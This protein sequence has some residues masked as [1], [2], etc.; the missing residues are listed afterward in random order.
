METL[1]LQLDHGLRS[2]RLSLELELGAETV[3][4]VGPSGAGKSSVLRAIAGL[5]RPEHGVVRLGDERWLDT[6]NGIDV[7]PERRRVGLVFQEYALFPHLSVRANVEFGGRARA[8]ELLERFRIGHLADARPTAISGGE[9]QRVAVARALARDPGVLLLDEPL[10]ALDAYTRAHVRTE[11]R[12]LLQE[13][14]LPTV[15]VTH[16]FDDAAALADR[17]GVLVDG[18]LLQVAGPSELVASPADS[19]VAGFTGANVLRGIASEGPDG[20]TAV[21]LDAGFTAYT[22]DPGRGGVTLA[23]YPWEVSVAR[24]APDDSAVNHVRA[25]IASLVPLGNRTRVRIGPLT[26]EITARSADRLALREGDVVVASFKATGARL[27]QLSA[28]SL[29]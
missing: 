23:V 18:R 12:E 6:A 10:S 4:L 17:V 29:G 1:E 24:E 19:F 21:A 15:I 13:L 27:L 2:F 28:A 20:L 22:V 11:L 8:R 25:P 9:R 16:D 5:L 3:A 26:A 14:A 7:P